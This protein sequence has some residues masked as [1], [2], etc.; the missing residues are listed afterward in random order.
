MTT[1]FGVQLR[2]MSENGSV[3]L[4]GERPTWETQAEQYSDAALCS[5]RLPERIG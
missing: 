5:D 3:A 1:G 2:G 4:S